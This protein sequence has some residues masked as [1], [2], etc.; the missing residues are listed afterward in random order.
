MAAATLAAR[1]AP[2]AGDEGGPVNEYLFLMHGGT[3]TEPASWA[4]Y[5]ARLRSAGCFLGGSSIGG[6]I[7][8]T[9][10][11]PAPELTRHL[12]GYIKI[13]AADLDEATALLAGNPV[14]D[15]G[16]TVEIRELPPDDG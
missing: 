11:G 14:Y 4:A 1:G 6:G 5:L 12:V 8:A 16:G 3:T 10:S 15:A 9:R 13:R 7:C 2:L